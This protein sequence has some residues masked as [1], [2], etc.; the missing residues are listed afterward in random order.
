LSIREGR[1]ESDF[2]KQS[3]MF[4]NQA[5]PPRARAVS[6]TGLSQN[7]SLGKKSAAKNDQA[8]GDAFDTDSR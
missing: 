4:D 3:R 5:L 7:A 6:K 1:A 8:D 2:H